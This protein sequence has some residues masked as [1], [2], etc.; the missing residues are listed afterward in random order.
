MNSYGV[1][2][3]LTDH[4]AVEEL[5]LDQSMKRNDLVSKAKMTMPYVSPVRNALTQAKIQNLYFIEQIKMG[6]FGPIFLVRNDQNVP[7][8]LRGLNKKLLD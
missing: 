4:K 8:V 2:A 5:G 3:E 6:Q 1:L 7:F